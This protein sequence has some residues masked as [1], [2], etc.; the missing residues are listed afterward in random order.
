M[1]PVYVCAC[2][3]A[4]LLTAFAADLPP[5]QPDL[6]VVLD[7]KG[8][9]TSPTIREMQR[10]ASHIIGASGIQLGWIRR[11][12]AVHSTF[13]DLVVITFKGSCNYLPALL[14]NRQPGPYAST[15]IAAGAVQPFGDVDCD[16]VVNF[17]RMAMGG[18]DFRQPDILVGRALGRVV[19]HELVHM[20]TKL[21][22]HAREGVEKAALSGRLLIAASLSLSAFDVDRL[23]LER[24]QP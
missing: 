22:Q 18:A 17:V 14:S 11:D 6:T 16:R 20:L 12:D 10:E 2:L 4:G 5:S 23:R 13:N 8:S 1:R 21:D 7:F 3:L 19:A 9:F 24:K 15:W